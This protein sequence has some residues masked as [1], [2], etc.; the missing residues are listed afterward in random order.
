M[1]PKAWG[2]EQ[3]IEN[4]DKYCCKILGLNKGYQ[5]SLHY[6]KNKDETFLVTVGHVRLELGDEVLHLRPGSFARVPQNTLHRF[7][8]IED[9]VIIEVSTHHEDS[10]SYRTEESRKMDEA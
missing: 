3:W 9:S 10:D 4:N 1:V 6:H 8:G 7:A 2:Y 5:C